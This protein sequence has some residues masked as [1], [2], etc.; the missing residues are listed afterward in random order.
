MGW[1]VGD[2]KWSSLCVKKNLEISGIWNFQILFDNPETWRI[3]NTLQQR[4]DVVG[5]PWVCYVPMNHKYF[6]PQYHPVASTQPVFQKK[7]GPFGHWLWQCPLD[8]CLYPIFHGLHLGESPMV[9]ETQMTHDPT[10]QAAS[11]R[12]TWGRTLS[13]MFGP[14]QPLPPMGFD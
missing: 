10:L 3:L 5:H 11:P 6:L 4:S 1:K 2:S 13:K 8:T 9:S 14:S 12:L 7:N